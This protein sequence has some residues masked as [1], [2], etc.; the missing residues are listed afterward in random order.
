[1]DWI[2]RVELNNEGYPP[3]RRLLIGRTGSRKLGA[4]DKETCKRSDNRVLLVHST[5]RRRGLEYDPAYSEAALIARTAHPQDMKVL[6]VED[7][8]ITGFTEAIERNG[9]A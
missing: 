9:T 5:V 1:M 6:W 2:P 8:E 4:T 7:H 3:A